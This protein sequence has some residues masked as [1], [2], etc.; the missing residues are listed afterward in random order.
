MSPAPSSACC[1]SSPTSTLRVRI[2]SAA[3]SRSAR[4]STSL[5]DVFRDQTR[6]AA[7]TRPMPRSAIRMATGGCS[8]RS[9]RGFRAQSGRADDERR[10]PGRLSAE[11]VPMD[12]VVA[13]HHG[14]PPSEGE[15]I[16]CMREDGLTPYG[17]GNAPGDTYGWHEHHYEK[18]LY[19]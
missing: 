18:V 17:W 5:G 16:A 3:A 1:W 19:C 10:F 6:K 14:P 8:R 13:R 11:E 12:I 9:R 15:I 2:S 7:L 4:C